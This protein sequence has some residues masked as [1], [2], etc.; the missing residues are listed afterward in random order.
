[1]FFGNGGPFGGGGGMFGEEREAKEVDN[2]GLY[3]V[4]GVD[5]KASSSQI[6]KAFFKLA[7]KHHPDKGGDTKTF[8]AMS[9]AKDILLDENKRKVYD[10]HGIEGINKGMGAGGGGGGMDIFEQMF[11]MQGGRG[12]GRS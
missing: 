6:K 8:Q 3:K 4:L 9:Q 2:E 7:K 1:M 5:K 12:G 10:R 11:N